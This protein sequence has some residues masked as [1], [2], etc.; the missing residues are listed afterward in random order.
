MGLE[1][2]ASCT[3]GFQAASQQ[4]TGTVT[5]Q[6]IVQG[7]AT[8]TAYTIN[9]ANQYTLRVRVHCPEDQRALAIYRSYGDSGSIAYGGQWNLT[10]A[11]LLF[12]IQ[13]FV[14]GV[15]G[16]P[17]TLYDGSVASVPGACKVVAVSSVNLVGTMRSL[18][19]TNLGSGWVVCTPSGGTPYTRRIG[20]ATQ[21][22]ECYLQHTGRLVFYTGFVPP[23]GEQIAVTYRSVGRAVGHAVNATSQQALALA[24]LPAVA[25]WIGSVTNPPARSSAD[26]RNAAL[27]MSQAAAS[28][29]ALWRGTYKTTGLSLSA[30]VWPGDALQ[31][32]AP[33]TDLNAQVVVRTVKLSYQAS[34]PDVVAYV[35]TFA[36]DWADDLAIKTSA[37]VPTDTWLPA[38]VE[39]VY[40]ANLKA[41]AVTSMSGSTITINTGATAPTGGGFEIRTRDFCFMA[42][43]DPD[44]VMR[45]SQSSMTFSRASA[46]DRYYIRMYDGSTPPNYSEFSAALF[47]NLPL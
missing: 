32:N 12:E 34:Y 47:I 20:A 39:P 25:A 7:T 29:S 8:G 43:E 27:A 22:S 11:K 19:L 3:A 10:P 45:G 33:S 15:A 9:T 6:P 17:V 28:V 18:N 31:L 44:L 38:L 30:D 42:G 36:N 41:L 21:A 1:T 5:L 24:G 4:G 14:N 37:S 35:I 23:A 16:M 13:E 26:C 2:L 40:L 46:S